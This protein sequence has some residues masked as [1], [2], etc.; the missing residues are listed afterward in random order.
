MCNRLKL[1][2]SQQR[3][4]G[5]TSETKA[6][7]KKIKFSLRELVRTEIRNL[8]KQ[9]II[10]DVT[11]EATPWLSQF[12]IVVKQGNKTRL[13]IDMDNANTA[14]DRTNLPTP[15]VDDLSFR[16]KI[17]QYFMKLDLNGAF[18]RLE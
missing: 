7:I 6:S 15:T 2:Q 5:I 1:T 17:A 8:E 9:E 11:S 18:H 3:N 12:T 16:L 10:E 14:N 13:C 4:I